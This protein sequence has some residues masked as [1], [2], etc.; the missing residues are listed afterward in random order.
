MS[1]LLFLVGTSFLFS[2]FQGVSGFVVGE[3]G[4]VFNLGVVIILLAFVLFVLSSRLKVLEEFREP[5]FYDGIGQSAT[6]MHGKV[7][8]GALRKQKLLRKAR[9]MFIDLYAKEPHQRELALFVE[10]LKKEGRLK[11]LEKE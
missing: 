4:S 3:G 9:E 1:L 5:L 10:R 6:K 11:E 2:R 8:L 7:N